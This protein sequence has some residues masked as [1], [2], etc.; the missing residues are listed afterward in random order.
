MEEEKFVMF[1]EEVFDRSVRLVS[2]WQ[3]V[4]WEHG[5]LNTGLYKNQTNKQT[6]NKFKQ[7]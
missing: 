5:V 3:A 7:T 1:F 6:R 2:L 4:G